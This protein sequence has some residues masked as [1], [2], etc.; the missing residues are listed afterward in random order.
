MLNIFHEHLYSN[1]LSKL[2]L[3]REG[4]E[5]K[6]DF[7]SNESESGVASSSS[8]FHYTVSHISATLST[9]VFERAL[10]VNVCRGRIEWKGHG[11]EIVELGAEVKK[12][13]LNIGLKIE[14]GK[15]RIYVPEHFAL[16]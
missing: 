9:N 2:N 10:R 15:F 5:E 14:R 3:Q 12:G 6:S 16:I 13:K 11:W 7:H 1:R 4:E 8:S